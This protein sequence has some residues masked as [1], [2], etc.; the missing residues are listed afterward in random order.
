[1]P[2]GSLLGSC[3]DDYHI[4]WTNFRGAD[5]GPISCA[6]GWLTP[7]VRRCHRPGHVNM[8]T[9]QRGRGLALSC[10]V[11]HWGHRPT[12]QRVASGQEPLV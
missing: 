7:T 6:V 9:G 3:R 10:I 8:P 4:R 5:Q 12:G 1:L 2:I 11:G